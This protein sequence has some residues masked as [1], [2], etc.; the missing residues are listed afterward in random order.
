MIPASGID[1][2]FAKRWANARNIRCF[3]SKRFFVLLEN[4][5]KTFSSSL[6]GVDM[7]TRRRELFTEMH[8]R[9]VLEFLRYRTAMDFFEFLCQE[10]FHVFFHVLDNG[11]ESSSNAS[12]FSSI[13]SSITSMRKH[14]SSLEWEMFTYFSS[15]QCYRGLMTR[16]CWCL[17]QS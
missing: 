3:P 12:N 15:L 13:T 1:F 5:H 4:G 17:F 7:T 14:V 11:S 8:S 10:M 2:V 6:S 16:T 9:D